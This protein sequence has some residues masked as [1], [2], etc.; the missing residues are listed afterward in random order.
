MRNAFFSFLFL[1]PSDAWAC[2]TC[3][4]LTDNEGL[5]RGFLIGGAVLLVCVF[6]IIGTIV[7]YVKRSEKK[8]REKFVKMGLMK[9]GEKTSERWPI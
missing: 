2:A 9:E 4:G 3:F 6:S 7:F 5:V 1:I 8:K